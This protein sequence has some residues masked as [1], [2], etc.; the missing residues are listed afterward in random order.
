MNLIH[1]TITTPLICFDCDNNVVLYVLAMETACQ[2]SL[3]TCEEAHGL[4]ANDNI[5]G[6]NGRRDIKGGMTWLRSSFTFGIPML[7]PSRSMM[8]IRCMKQGRVSKNLLRAG[9]NHG[10]SYKLLTSLKQRP[11]QIMYRQFGNSA[12]SVG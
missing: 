6:C 12:E 4:R 5:T 9:R 7:N 8:Q 10:Q 1:C 2:R 3:T 11:L